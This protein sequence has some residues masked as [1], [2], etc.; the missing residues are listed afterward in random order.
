MEKVDLTSI[1][2]TTDSNK[3]DEKH[4]GVPK[5]ERKERD[6]NEAI[7][8]LKKAQHDLKRAN[9]EIEEKE[10]NKQ[11]IDKHC[12]RMILMNYVIG[13]PEE[14]SEYKKNDFKKMSTNELLELRKNFDSIIVSKRS[15]KDTQKII[16]TLI[17]MLETITLMT[18]PIKC[19][20]L[21]DI[22]LNDEDVKSDIKHICLRH[23]G[24]VEIMPEY[25][26]TF[27]LFQNIMALH[28]V[29]SSRPTKNDGAKLIKVNEKYSDL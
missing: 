5:E 6:L 2:N 4:D 1:Q 17:R 9:A 16:F 8:D 22:M 28:E 25:R 7:N 11:K 18:T 27:K 23:L 10:E 14:L 3:H 21:A 20:G 12:L 24:M 19:N 15:M 29:N 13:F 26:L